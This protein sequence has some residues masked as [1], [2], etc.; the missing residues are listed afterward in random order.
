[1]TLKDYRLS[2][3]IIIITLIVAAATSQF[4]GMAGAV[5]VV[6]AGFCMLAL[7]VLTEQRMHAALQR[8][9]FQVALGKIAGDVAMI[10][11]PDGV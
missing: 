7:S 4:A 5:A 6:V 2:A 9:H 1:M 10:S 8:Q 3:G 11:G